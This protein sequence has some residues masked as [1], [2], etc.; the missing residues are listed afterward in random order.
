M[1]ETTEKIN[2][3]KGLKIF[4]EKRAV[5]DQIE[6][7][8]H[9]K[10]SKKCTLHWGVSKNSSGRWK[11]PLETFWPEGTYKFNQAALQTP[12]KSQDGDNYLLIKLDKSDD[13][14]GIPFVLFFP[15]EN[16][17][18]NN[19]GRN[20]F[21]KLPV[22]ASESPRETP[23]SPAPVIN[24][25]QILK[26]EIQGKE[27]VFE[28]VH[29]FD[30]ENHLAIGVTKEDGDFQVH[31]LSNIQ[32]SLILHWGVAQNRRNEWLLPPE[33][34][35]PPQSSVFDDKT[36]QTSF[37][38]DNNLNRLK[39][40]CPENDLPIG[41]SFVL[42]H[43]DTG[44]WY[45]KNGGNFYIPLNVL[46]LSGDEGELESSGPI[47]LA[48]EIIGSESGRNSWTLMHR[49]NLCFDLLDSVRNNVQG[50]AVIF[51]WLRY[52]AL[53]QLDWQ[54]RYNTKP[55]ELSHSQ[56]RLSHKLAQLYTE[57]GPDEREVVR[58]IFTTLGRGGEGG[59]GQ[60]IRDE[61][62]HIMHRHKIKEVTGHFM[63]EW[64]QKLHNNTT[65]DDIVICEAYL[66]F[67]KSDGD[68]NMFYNTLEQ[69]GVTRKRL[70]SFD[71]P[72]VTDPDFAPHIKDGLIHDFENF[73]NLLKSVHSAT[74]FLGAL[75]AA[76]HH[77]DNELNHKLRT[78]YE[79]RD[80]KD[81]GLI[82]LVSAVTDVRRIF[83]NHLSNGGNSDFIR[84]ILYLDI[85]CE[86]FLRMVI[87]RKI[88]ESISGRDLI[89][90][91]GFMVENMRL[92][93][94]SNEFESAL[95]EWNKLK[96]SDSLKT[97]NKIDAIS[98]DRALHARA[99]I[100]RISRGLGNFVDHY[101]RLFQKRAEYLGKAFNADSWTIELFSQEVV[102]GS[103]G[104]VLSV[105]I[106]Q[107][108]PL[109][110][111]AAKLGSWQ[112][113]SGK[114]ITGRVEVN[115]LMDIQNKIYDYPTIIITD[116]VTGD[117]EI[118]EGVVG[119]ITP[120]VVDILS[121][122]SVRARNASIVFATCYDSDIIDELKSYRGQVL[123][124]NVGASSDIE[125]NI[126]EDAEAGM[127][128]AESPVHSSIKCKPVKFK[129]YVLS[130]H[131]FTEELVGGKS[132]NL[133]SLRDSLPSW[134]NTPRSVAIP[135]GVCE[136]VLDDKL[137]NEVKKRYDELLSR[138]DEKPE[139]TVPELRQTI[140]SLNASPELLSELKE[141][142]KKEGFKWP[143]DD[144]DRLWER[145]TGVWA[146]K[147]TERAY[148][149][150]KKWGIKHDELSMAVLI[151]EVVNAEYAFVIHTSNPF[152]NDREEVYTEVVAGLGETLCSGN[153]P[154]RALSFSCRKGSSLSPQ[155]VSYPSKDVALRGGG[156]I[157]RSDSNGEDLE[158]YAGA[159][160]YDSFLLD[161]PRREM[162]DYTKVP[163]L[164]DRKFREEFMTM[165]SKIGIEIE[166]ILN[167]CPQDIEGA[168][169]G[170]KYY[171]VQVRPQVGTEC[172]IR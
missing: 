57:S 46:S 114:D 115:S 124:L 167:E 45:K 84:D 73:L 161:P 106:R 142:M 128:Q 24:S 39:I 32:G 127:A 61:V 58:L 154:G 64:H 96:E 62:L 172:E 82:N 79:N 138:V 60:R 111:S 156:I 168:Y 87:E 21:I 54:R 59:K 92:C 56:H 65:P 118:P 42:K 37:V 113:I 141:V 147:W 126:V 63:E 169:S 170:D 104:F 159:G 43:N 97:S 160:L 150:R 135:F 95:G 81:F 137:N 136:K 1:T 72:I 90:L 75:E 36:A 41:I 171:V 13:F 71:R 20:Y 93:H 3:R 2:A 52:S 30:S 100:D 12:F 19:K 66:E 67:L 133:T 143:S 23:S 68:V 162:V 11:L 4:V 94:R 10:S 102:R 27:I 16:R 77:L 155:L 164:W 117:E 120:V 91:I 112:V 130:S 119:V 85:A 151:Q 44:H 148:V 105:L 166:H 89:E 28:Q 50:L 15:D 129:T 35:R 153:Y 5:D 165:V 74:D 14:S 40:E 98:Q 101:D 122:V 83:N 48:D 53:R 158:D 110:R 109:L 26:D 33:S 157:F 88:H 9:L 152:N 8:F 125:F 121:H 86:E 146:S 80:N 7:S 134:I 76:E 31:L 69:G 139:E 116:K 140:K 99:V 131:D 149:S 108:D 6:V 22:P 103:V 17:W 38:F 18:D 123:N 34:L 132:L 51:V 29:N 55:R 144:K 70:E 163:L 145:I 107:L 47:W 49:F 25:G 78:I